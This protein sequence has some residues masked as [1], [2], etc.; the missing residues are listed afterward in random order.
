MKEIIF[1]FSTS[2]IRDYWFNY[3]LRKLERYSVE[4]KCN[5]IAR[6]MKF[7]N[8]KITFKADYMWGQESAGNWDKNQYWVEDLFDN[9]FEEFFF[10]LVF[11]NKPFEGEDNG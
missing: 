11:Q 5:K 4:I 7:L 1:W 2:K 3:A 9:N 8:L 6:W 10:E